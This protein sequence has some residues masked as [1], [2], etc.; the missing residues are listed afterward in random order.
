[1]LAAEAAVDS[2]F[3]D[4]RTNIWDGLSK[5]LNVNLFLSLMA[6]RDSTLFTSCWTRETPAG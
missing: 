4:G 5:A 2:L 1:M 3:A 6:W